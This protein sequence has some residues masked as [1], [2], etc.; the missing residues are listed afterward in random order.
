MLFE[1]HDVEEIDKYSSEIELIGVNNRNLR[2][3]KTDYKNSIDILKYL[4]SEAVKISES[5]I[6]DPVI[7]H[8]L[9]TAGYDGFLI[10]EHFM[11]NANPG[12]SILKFVKKLNE[13]QS[14]NDN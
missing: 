6:N 9:R 12:D 3:Y 13:L 2:T 8:E 10:G 4:P 11:A 1:V 7:V 5:G 14:G